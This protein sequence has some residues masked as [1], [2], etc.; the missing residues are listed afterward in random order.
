M[1]IIP[2]GLQCSSATFKKSL[3]STATLPF[4]WMFANIQFV[5]KILELLLVENMDIDVLVTEHF[6]CCDKRASV[7]HQEHYYTCENGGGL[8]NTKYGVI[9]PH[10]KN[11]KETIDKY[12]RRL[13]RLKDIILN[14]TDTLVFVY[15]SQSSLESGHFTIDG[16]NVVKDVYVTASKIYRLIGSFRDNYRMVIFDSIQEEPESDIGKG[17]ILVK[18]DKCSNWLELTSQIIERA[19]A[20]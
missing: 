7:D 20:I 10:D 9:F 19:K 18:M 16:N 2:I 14:S 8:Y 17:I 11:D 15:S 4:D 6:F 1:F 13:E 12:I 3:E 5:Y